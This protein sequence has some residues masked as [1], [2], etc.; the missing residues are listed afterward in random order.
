MS[1]PQ[2]DISSLPVGSA[3]TRDTSPVISGPFD[4]SDSER[5]IVNGEQANS[6][7]FTEPVA[8]CGLGLRLPGGV[9][10]GDSF[11]DLLVNGRDARMP[12]PASR[13]NIS[14][15]DGSLDGRDPIKTSHGYFLDEDLS[16][17]DA[18]FFSMTKNEL[19]KC[20]P[21]QRQLLEVSRECLEDAGETNY[22]GRNVGCYIGN[23]GHDWMEM[24]LR[25]PQHSRSYNVIGYSD[26]ILANRVSYEYDLRGP[27]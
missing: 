9:R 21:Q 13:Y 20:D 16:S 10:Y 17:L 8:I 3:S 15:F 14:G 12:I 1:F 5:D 2:S 24:S 11:W 6:S 23:F 4:S 18:S 19:E 7:Q 25:E 26:M 27:R 22:R